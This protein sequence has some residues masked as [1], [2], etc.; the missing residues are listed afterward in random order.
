MIRA[1]VFDFDGL[2]VETETP[3]LRAW[4]EIYRSYGQELPV[5]RWKLTIGSDDSAFD[6]L[7]ELAR[8][9][10]GLDLEAIKTR[11][12]ARELELATA[13]PLLPGVLDYIRHARE[14]GL[15]LAVASSS[16]YRWVGGQLQR[17]GL[18]TAFDCIIPRDLVA[19]VKPAP[20]LYRMACETLGIKGNEA[21]ALE[22][23]P[24]GIRAAKAAG[25]FAVAVPH[26]HTRQMDF[27]MAD[28][29]VNSLADVSLERLLAGIPAETT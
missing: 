13:Q 24:N 4:Q 26:E 29:C 1:L 16:S 5:E 21:I 2:I 17:R 22:D 27:S 25:M 28:M 3:I 8:L 11:R 19:R 10:A 23:A 20:D 18:L 6:A 15:M 7:A 14:L 9:V 12:K